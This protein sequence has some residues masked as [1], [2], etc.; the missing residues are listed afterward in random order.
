LEVVIQQAVTVATGHWRFLVMPTG[1]G[2]MQV[3]LNKSWALECSHEL[4]LAN[5]I[6]RFGMTIQGIYICIACLRAR[7][8]K[9]PL[10]TLILLVGSSCSPTPQGPFSDKIIQEY[11]SMASLSEEK[12]QGPYI[13]GK[14][15]L[16]NVGES[17]SHHHETAFTTDERIE[18]E[19]QTVSSAHQKIDKQI[20]AENPSEVGTVVLLKW[21]KEVLRTNIAGIE[22]CRVVC[23]VIVVD[24]SNHYVVDKT[25][26]AGSN[27]EG[28][29]RWGSSPENEI[30]KYVNALPRREAPPR[31]APDRG[32]SAEPPSGR[33]DTRQY[34]DTMNKL[35]FSYP[36]AW[37]EATPAE[38]REAM[39]A[40]T[41]K[42]LT[43]VL[44]DPQDRTQNVNVQVLPTAAQDLSEAAFREFVQTMDRGF[45]NASPGF[46]KL[47]SRVGPLRDMASLQYIFEATRPDGVR[48]R[49]KQ[50]RTGKPGREVVITFSA[51]AEAYDKADETC[52]KIITNTLTLD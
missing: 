48:L 21:A 37:K 19:S 9:L 22:F 20:R 4:T 16:I 14:A 17:I 34:S 12:R 29:H 38:V 8:F 11:A 10:L 49:Q 31:A 43:V 32:S 47:S 15:V 23:E 3:S 28:L 30:V 27:P 39:G 40:N 52:F 50:L 45:Q 36:A 41:S 35:S 42:Y 6:R 1:K 18:I 2:F 44:F 7:A 46:R 24:K 51:R 13:V 33:S 5:K 25:L 26:F